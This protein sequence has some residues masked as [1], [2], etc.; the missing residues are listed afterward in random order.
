VEGTDPIG[1]PFGAI[2]ITGQAEAR[3]LWAHKDL[4]L[5]SDGYK[6]SV[7]GHGARVLKLTPQ[8]KY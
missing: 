8:H 7:L 2:G 1:L 5:I 6:V 4:G 3:D